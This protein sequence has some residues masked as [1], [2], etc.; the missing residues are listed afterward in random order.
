MTTTEVSVNYH[1]Q[2]SHRKF[3]VRRNKMDAFDMERNLAKLS[4]SEFKSQ[5]AF[6][7]LLAIC[8]LLLNAA[9]FA[10]DVR[11]VRSGSWSDGSTWDSGN[12]PG[13]GDNVVVDSG[14]VVMYD[15]N[16]ST[17]IRTIHIRGTLEFSRSTDTQLDVGM[18]VVS[19]RETIDFNWDCSLHQGGPKYENA[20][21][22]AL[23]VGTFDNP[24]PANVTARIRLKHFSGLDPDCSPGI[25]T[26]NGRMDFHGAPVNK[27]WV[28]MGAGADEGDNT[29]TLAESVNWKAGDRIIVTRSQR[30]SGNIINTGSYK[31]NGQIETEERTIASI[32]GNTITLT[33]A[34]DHDHPTY[35]NGKYAGEVALLSRNVIVESKE[36][37]GERGHTMYHYQSRGSISY[38]EFAHLG[39][40]G[41]LA[42]YPV[43]FHVL[44]DS[45]RGSFI[46]GSSIWDSGNRFLTIHGTNYLYVKDNVGYK[47]LGHGYFM[48]DA[49]EVFNFLDNNLAVQCFDE[50]KLPNQALEYDKN[51]GAGFWWANARNAFT[52]NVAV[53]TDKYGFQYEIRE[54]IEGTVMMMDGRYVDN[55]QVNKLSNI[56]FEDNEAH[57][58]MEY[59]LALQG[60]DAPHADPFYVENM[61]IWGCWRA[62]RPDLNNFYFK[63]LSAWNHA[64]GMYAIDPKNGRVR[65]Y[66]AINTGN[67][68]MSFQDHPEGLI[69][70]E[71]VHI[72]NSNEWPFKVYGRDPRQEDC[73]I[74]VKDYTI[75]NTEYGWD[76]ASS[77]SGVEPT[78]YIALFLHDWFGP[79][80]DAKVIPHVQDP[81]DGLNYQTMTPM[82]RD[83]IKVAQ[84]NEPWPDNPIYL[85]DAMPPATTIIYPANQ[86]Q[87]DG[88]TNS[89]TVQGT[90]IDVSPITSLTVNG[91]EVTPIEENYRRWEVTLNNLPQGI[92]HLESKATDSKGNVE[93]NPHTIIIGIGATPVGTDSDATQPIIPA[94]YVLE[95][96]F[97][98]PFNPETQ[99]RFS[100]SNLNQDL[101][102]V[103]INIYNVL[104]RKVR[105]LVNQKMSPGQYTRTWD[106]RDDRGVSVSTGVYIYEM[107]ARGKNTAVFRE[108][109]KMLLVK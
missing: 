35:Q 69:T 103:Q 72:E 6:T 66:S 42:R 20:V 45:N 68:A 26:Y 88:Q 60:G 50:S 13:Q 27:T 14:H 32:S 4:I 15:K 51:D 39:K 101:S 91:V 77:T 33:E 19:T 106:G 36:P 84:T 59:G 55:V 95:D 46:I 47:A 31:D 93:L 8:L 96:N 52:N 7:L 11:S 99:I 75:I 38:A 94:G 18:I 89:V 37:N 80:Q 79:N 104:G 73:E 74:H 81:N 61:K 108:A 54:N 92:V 56:L 9:L 21:P 100:V 29:V 109:K 23:E 5:T 86:Q 28:K 49:T 48:E 64:Y 85:G 76:G 53:E 63:D 43:H 78:P 25:I 17:E 30:P 58:S 40:E 97:P 82:F 105:T 3:K 24:I 10:D 22:P 2:S 57:G 16:S 87:F 102:D 44:R 34:L 62:L 67:H 107:K 90:C 83:D 41:V 71:G 70:F 12:V 98:N 65:N 1:K